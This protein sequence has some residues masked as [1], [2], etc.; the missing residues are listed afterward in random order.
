MGEMRFNG[1]G[2]QKTP[3]PRLLEDAG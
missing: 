1:V 2:A 3:R